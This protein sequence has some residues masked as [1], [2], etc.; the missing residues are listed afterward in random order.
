MEQIFKTLSEIDIKSKIEKKGNQNYLSWA[1]AWGFAK[2]KYPSIQRIVY[3]DSLTG[4]NYFNDGLTAYVKVG[5]VIEGLEHIDYLPIMSY[6][7]KSIKIQEVTSFEV[8]KTIQRST[9]KALALHGLGLQMWSGEDLIT[10][11]SAP[12]VTTLT[13]LTIGDANWNKVLDYI[14]A[15]KQLGLAPI[16]KNLQ[17]K[18]KIDTLTK[19]ELGKY[20]G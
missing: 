3:E 6:N 8:S 10:T 19:K 12:K 11:V 13:D 2:Q 4:L 16:I 7:N 14:K 9:V 1:N 17:I 5:I 15:N 20:V 18:Y